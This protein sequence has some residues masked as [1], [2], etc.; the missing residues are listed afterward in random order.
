ML[1]MSYKDQINIIQVAEQEGVELRRSG[2]RHVGC[3]PFH[4]EKTGSFY[5]FDD[6]R[7]KCFGCGEYGDGIDLIRKLHGLTF[8]EALKHLGIESG[9]L[10]KDAI[11]KIN[12]RKRRRKLLDDFEKWRGDYLAYLGTMINRT[13]KLMLGRIPPA[14]LDLYAPLLHGLPLWKHQSEILL[15]GTDEDKLSLLK[16]AHRNGKYQFRPRT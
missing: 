1:I 13:M 11:R 3:C 15:K 12:Q 9:G 7:F 5:I 8:K 14:D 6:Q 2:T 16:E 4:E 10:S